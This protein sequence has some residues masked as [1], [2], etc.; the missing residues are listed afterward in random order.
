MNEYILF[1]QKQN[2]KLN[3]TKTKKKKEDGLEYYWSD[4]ILDDLLFTCPR[5]SVVNLSTLF[6][7][8][9]VLNH[10]SFSSDAVKLTTKPG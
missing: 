7:K 10:T 6:T 5:L 9:T 8:T 3:K 1:K 2:K 4:D